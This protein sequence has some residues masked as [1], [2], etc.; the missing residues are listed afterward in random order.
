MTASRSPLTQR[1]DG[2]DKM[3]SEAKSGSSVS[4]A[5]MNWVCVEVSAAKGCRLVI[6]MCSK[7]PSAYTSL[8]GVTGSPRI[9]S[10]AAKAGVMPSD[11][12][13]SGATLIGAVL[14]IDAETLSEADLDIRE[15][16]PKSNNLATP[17]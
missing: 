16:T 10:G 4:T 9:C 8:A 11:C 13:C 12:G 7:M 6:S 17:S 14:A 1:L 5:R 15:A 3:D 2:D